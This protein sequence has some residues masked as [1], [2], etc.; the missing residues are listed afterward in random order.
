[1]N[2]WIT[3]AKTCW[4]HRK[5]SL[6]EEMEI[7]ATQKPERNPPLCLVFDQ[8]LPALLGLLGGCVIEGHLAIGGR[9]R[10]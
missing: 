4:G 1:M 8:G 6:K 5:Q 9:S 2:F 7:G 10:E 3:E